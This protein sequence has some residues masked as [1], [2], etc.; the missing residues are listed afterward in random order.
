MAAG[1]SIVYSIPTVGT[2]VG[3]LAQAKAGLYTLDVETGDV[4]TPIRLEIIA[5]PVS[6]NARR[7][8]ATWK[9]NPS[10][11]DAPGSAT[12]GRVSLSFVVDAALGS[13]CTR[14]DLLNE[15]RWF[16]GALLKST[17]LEG[18]VDGSNL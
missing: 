11:T 1:S 13:V 5:S 2:T 10:T 17:L 8:T 3:T 15:C 9:F 12:K 7:V 6:S 4:D 18:L 14:T 16:M